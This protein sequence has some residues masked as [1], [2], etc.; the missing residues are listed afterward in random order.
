MQTAA[1]PPG[2]L[3]L[4]DLGYFSLPTLAAYDA[5][6]VYWLT[7]YH[8]Q[9]L[10]FDAQGQ[11]LAIAQ[12]LRHTAQE[13]FDWAVQ[14][15]QAHRLDCRLVAVRM[16]PPVAAERRRKAQ[17]AA[18]REGRT[19]TAAQRTLLGWSLFLTNVPASQLSIDEVLTVA[20]VRWQIEVLFKLWKTQGHLDE[21]RSHKPYRILCE[22][23][24]KLL[25]L[26]L[27]H[28]LL[29]LTGWHQ[30]NRSWFK[31]GQTIRQHSLRLGCALACVTQLGQI[32]ETLARCLTVGARLNTRKTKPSTVQR[33]LAFSGDP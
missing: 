13:R 4:A 31:A 24:A 7:R 23:Y 26:L 22:V 21:F 27:Q 16:P 9:C 29:V 12:V 15:S 32:F 18:R 14:V 33:L 25:G 30:L 11:P 5:Q 6:G 20:R 19:L 2:A 8:P 3:R 17:A 28:W 1:L 10:V